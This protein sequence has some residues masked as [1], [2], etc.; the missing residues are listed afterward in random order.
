MQAIQA[1]TKEQTGSITIYWQQCTEA[2]LWTYKWVDDWDLCGSSSGGGRERRFPN[3]SQ[4]TGSAKYIH[5]QLQILVEYFTDLNNKG[6]GRYDIHAYVHDKN[7]DV[8]FEKRITIDN[9]RSLDSIVY[10]KPYNPKSLL[11]NYNFRD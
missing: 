3:E 6:E 11:G 9:N 2:G 5:E 4:D 8:I 10:S 7:D 1:F